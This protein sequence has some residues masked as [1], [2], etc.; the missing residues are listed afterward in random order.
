MNLNRQKK[1][2]KDWLLQ[3]VDH[4]LEA[5]LHL[6]ISHALWTNWCRFTHDDTQPPVKIIVKRMLVQVMNMMEISL[7]L[8]CQRNNRKSQP[9]PKH[10]IEELFERQGDIFI[11]KMREVIAD[12]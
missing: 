4:P 10:Q 8:Y 5:A 3:N 11:C 6:N 2:R 7:L 1:K 9:L 12:V